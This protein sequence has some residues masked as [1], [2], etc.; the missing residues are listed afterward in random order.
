MILII[1]KDFLME[2]KCLNEKK[3]ESN[4][5]FVIRLYL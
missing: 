5:N 3:N 1:I 4:N 2:S